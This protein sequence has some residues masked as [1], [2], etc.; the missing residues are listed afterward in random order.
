ML[1]LLLKRAA[2]AEAPPIAGELARIREE[3]R[4][5]IDAIA[6]ADRERLDRLQSQLDTTR[7]FVAAAIKTSDDAVL[8]KLSDL[9]R[10]QQEQMH[11]L[12]AFVADSLNR[13]AQ[14]SDTRLT[15]V[16]KA[17]DALRTERG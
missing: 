13:L 2:P 7:Q 16:E 1:A 11:A 4:A 12:T 10:S 14:S 9:A 8:R 5:A 15:A 6:Y 3:S 17:L